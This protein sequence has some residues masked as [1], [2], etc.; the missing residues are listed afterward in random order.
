M[1]NVPEGLSRRILDAR[2]RRFKC[3]QNLTSQIIDT[4]RLARRRQLARGAHE[5]L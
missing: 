5:K 3:A 2:A 4:M 1:R